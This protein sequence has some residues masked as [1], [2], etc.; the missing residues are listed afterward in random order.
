M[1][2]RLVSSALVGLAF[3]ITTLFGVATASAD[4]VELDY[5]CSCE[6]RA[7][8]D[9]CKAKTTPTVTV[10]SSQ[11]KRS[12]P[13]Q[14]ASTKCFREYGKSCPKHS[15]DAPVTKIGGP[16][17]VDVKATSPKATDGNKAG[18]KNKQVEGLVAFASDD[19]NKYTIV[20]RASNDKARKYQDKDGYRPKPLAVKLK[21][22]KKGKYAGL[23]TLPDKKKLKKMTDEERADVDEEVADLEGDGWKFDKELLRDSDGRAVHGDY[24]LQG[25]YKGKKLLDTNAKKG[26]QLL[27]ELNMAVDPERTEEDMWLFQHGGNDNYRKKGD[28]S[29]MGRFPDPDEEFLIIEPDG[30]TVFIESLADLEKYYDEHKMPWHYQ[31]KNRN[32]KK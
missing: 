26:K 2:S 5:S 20:I 19:D 8:N 27:E 32:K 9:V 29:E 21:T 15:C 18:M 23:V 17:P 11:G 7:D 25:L 3:T 1:K 16:R 14:A 31:E 30:D 10:T 24:D 4:K 13:E 6:Q 22:A 28:T 12:D